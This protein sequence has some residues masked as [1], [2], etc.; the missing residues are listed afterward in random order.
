MDIKCPHCDSRNVKKSSAMVDQGTRNSSGISRG[1]WVSS[2]GR[3]GV[4]QRKYSSTSATTAAEL[5]APPTPSSPMI[6]YLVL[7]GLVVLWVPISMPNVLALILG[8]FVLAIVG[9]VL[10]V[11]MFNRPSATDRAVRQRWDKQWYC[12]RCGELFVPDTAAPA[13][14]NGGSDYDGPSG[15]VRRVSP[16]GRSLYIDRVQN[17]VQRAKAMTDR[18]SAG[19]RAIR[20]RAT[21][22]GTFD[23]QALRCDLGLMSRLSSL[24]LVTYDV[25]NHEFRIEMD[26]TGSTSA[27]WWQ[28]TFG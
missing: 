5:N 20:K 24:G 27:G 14:R 2:S 4:S 23:P 3:F 21:P 11:A 9:S 6:G 28:R 22:N 1:G 19:L 26:H 13:D 16:T 12:L 10:L 17:P 8:E 7:V 25:R 15:P 18:D